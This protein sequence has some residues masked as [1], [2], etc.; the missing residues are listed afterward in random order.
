MDLTMITCIG[1]VTQGI[2]CLFLG[3]LRCV[4]MVSQNIHLRFVMDIVLFYSY[5]HYSQFFLLGIRKIQA[6]AVPACGRLL[7]SKALLW[8]SLW[9]H[10]RGVQGRTGGAGCFC[11]VLITQHGTAGHSTQLCLQHQVHPG[12]QAAPAV[13][14]V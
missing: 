1:L 13:V 6:V 4:V 3:I 8:G 12:D 9:V 2:P 14:P 5:F 10:Q 11:I 7:R